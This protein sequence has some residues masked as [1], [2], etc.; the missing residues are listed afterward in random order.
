MLLKVL[1]IVR[2][3]FVSMNLDDGY[4]TDEEPGCHR[5]EKL[6]GEAA[7]PWTDFFDFVLP[8]FFTIASL[9]D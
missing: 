8:P 5:C 7:N 4:L 6:D 9:Y 2:M 1:V 3:L